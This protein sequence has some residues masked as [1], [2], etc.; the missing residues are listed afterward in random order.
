MIPNAWDDNSSKVQSE[1]IVMMMVHMI[2]SGVRNIAG[3]FWRPLFGKFVPVQDPAP[4]F[5]WT[6]LFVLE[7]TFSYSRL[8]FPFQRFRANESCGMT[9]S[10]Q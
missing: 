9:T 3:A 10:V 2:R 1:S 6:T 4:R 7:Y 8:E 5:S